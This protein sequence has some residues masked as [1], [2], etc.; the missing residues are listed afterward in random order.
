M[1]VDASHAA[2]LVTR[3]SCTGV[4]IFV[5]RAP[6]VW[7]SKKQNSIETSSFGSEFAALKTGVELL[8]G[9]RYKLQM[10]GVPINGY[11]HTL[12][13][14]MSVVKNSS[15][16]ESTLKKKSNSIAYHY[17]RSRCAADILRIEWINTKDQLADIL[18]KVHTGEVRKRLANMIMW[19]DDELEPIKLG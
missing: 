6:T 13:D 19:D 2:N 18:T 1:F 8:E 16:P 17:V 4:L 5:N 7:Y 11:C 10:M 15:V 3:Q 14:N 12:V 9:L